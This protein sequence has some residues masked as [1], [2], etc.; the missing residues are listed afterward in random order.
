MDAPLSL[1][2]ATQY[3]AAGLCAIPIRVD[4]TKA[5][6][7]PE[8]TTFKN[9]LPT[10]EELTQ[11]FPTEMGVAVICGKVSG[12]LETLDFEKPEVF[13][14][15][16][17]LVNAVQP[18]LM[19]KLVVTMTP[20]KYGLPG[21]HVRYRVSGMEVPGN[22][23]LAMS[24]DGRDC[25]IETRGEG[26]YALA[27][28]SAAQA[29]PTGKCYKNVQGMLS[30]IQ[31]ISARE[32]EIL[33]GC[34]ESFNQQIETPT[35]YHPQ[36]SNNGTGDRP[37]DIYNQKGD[38]SILLEHGWKLVSQNEAGRCMW[39][40]PGKDG[41]GISATSGFCRNKAGIPLFFV[42]ST[43]AAP[44][45][46][47]RAYDPFGVYA[48]LK[49]DGDLK[50]AGRALA[51]P[52]TGKVTISTPPAEVVAA[53]E[54]VTE[55]GEIILSD[56]LEREPFPIG[57]F[58]E[59]L[60]RTITELATVMACQ[61]DIV[62]TMML[63]LSSL[64]IGNTRKI[65]LKKTWKEPAS[66]FVAIVANPGEGKTPIMKQ[67]KPPVQQ[68][69][70]TLAAAYESTAQDYEEALEIWENNKGKV[71]PNPKPVKPRYKH[72]FTTDATTEKIASMLADNPRG[73]GID[74]D[75]LAALVKGM[76]QYKA[77]GQG[78]DRH[79]YLEGWA[80]NAL[81]VD[82]VST[83][84]PKIVHDPFF[85]V[86]GGIQPQMLGVLKDEFGRED[87]FV[88][89]FL[90]CCPPRRVLPPWNDDEVSDQAL[91]AWSDCFA[92]LLTLSMTQGDNGRQ[93]AW[94]CHLTPEAKV[95]WKKGYDG[96]LPRLNSLTACFGGA[97]HKIVAYAARLSL[98]MQMLYWACGE[99]QESQWI[100]KHAVW[101]GW[102][103]AGYYANQMRIVYTQ[104]HDRPE[105]MRAKEYLEWING[106]GGKVTKRE[107]M[108]YGPSWSRKSS[109]ILKMFQ[110]LQDRGMGTVHESKPQ[111]DGRKITWFETT[112][113]NQEAG[114]P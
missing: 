35:A 104:I 8:W 53:E 44:F 56:D 99:D 112:K 67:L 96:L 84:V 10:A 64:G 9:R 38:F 97:Y 5:P 76:N 61:P 40:R 17:E 26:G 80:Q 33:I 63:A 107:A 79:F 45:E 92:Q 36:T 28:G 25:L 23:K 12:N 6:S 46:S 83:D 7:I 43:N 34:A 21:R 85:C 114:E 18:N 101:A 1:Q 48:R 19:S 111:A 105:D 27:P 72:V 39:R 74:Q 42:F 30:K 71:T 69:Q 108:Q 24:A 73:I 103:L 70:D 11:W 82:R 113:V 90:F 51:P 100:G 52:P 41:P 93:R 22:T 14:Q 62:G 13:E 20:G 87:G 4:G 31:V 59:K 89:R 47:M 81:K 49:H 110:D 102:K 57:V 91:Q 29:H 65:S 3:R 58:P 98:I 109:L 32:R 16:Q 37:G 55:D 94:Y 77:N 60:Q 2:A 66:L 88:H 95:E 75:E 15:W 86:F 54:A 106:R 50:A 68:W 78:R